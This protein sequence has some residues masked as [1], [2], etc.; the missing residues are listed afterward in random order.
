MIVCLCLSF[1]LEVV[2]NRGKSGFCGGEEEEEE[3]CILHSIALHLQQASWAAEETSDL[4]AAQL[5]GRADRAR[6]SGKGEL[7]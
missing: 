2:N 3:V 7:S 6:A 5:C 1:F 4:S